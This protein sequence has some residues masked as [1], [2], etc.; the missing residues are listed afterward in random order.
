[1]ATALLKLDTATAAS[2]FTAFAALDISQRLSRMV[3]ISSH[4]LRGVVEGLD[5]TNRTLSSLE[6]I[7]ANPSAVRAD[8]LRRRATKAIENGWNE[9]ARRDLEES[10]AANPY[11]AGA[12]YLL[13]R[14]LYLSSEPRLAGDAYAKVARYGAVRSK[15]L[16][17]FSVLAGAAAYDEVGMREE[18]VGLL[19]ES[20]DSCDDCPHIHLALAIRTGSA[21]HLVR[22]IELDQS[23][24]VD[25]VA[26]HCEGIE[27]AASLVIQRGVEERASSAVTLCNRVVALVG[28]L[29]RLAEPLAG[30]PEL[31]AR[32]D[33]DAN[34]VGHLLALFAV[35][36]SCGAF[37]RM[38][39]PRLS[40]EH[41][42]ES[43]RMEQ[44]R[45]SRPLLPPAPP[46]GLPRREAK[47]WLKNATEA[48]EL[49]YERESPA[50]IARNKELRGLR[51]EWSASNASTLEQLCMAIDYFLNEPRHP[52]IVPAAILTVPE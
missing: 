17:A 37:L 29:P 35:I 32:T 49:A 22:A 30:C 27:P 28:T 8:E 23:I 16:A 41:I 11:D 1:M 45:P 2:V 18:A 20:L 46:V 47:R 38:V 9:E 33:V 31:P 40:W 7:A 42:Q 26:A 48:A 43:F 44:P 51:E 15:P 24:V 36:E 52:V 12:W 21:D 50:W 39:R 4:T 13:A 5:T 19:R 10:V 25:A 6:E 34:P 14:V 3:T